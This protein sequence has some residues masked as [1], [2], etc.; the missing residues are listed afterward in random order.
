MLIWSVTSGKRMIMSNGKQILVGSSKSNIFEHKWTDARGNEIKLVAHATSPMSTAS[1]SRQYDLF[2][3]G[4]SFFTLPKPYEI[5]LRGLS[6]TRIPGLIT[7]SNG[8]NNTQRRS[9][10]KYSDSGRNIVHEPDEVCKSNVV[11]SLKH[12]LSAV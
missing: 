11:R 6:D 1:I 3:N 12:C 7:Q 2:V 9:V 10:A 8:P 4:K 5:G